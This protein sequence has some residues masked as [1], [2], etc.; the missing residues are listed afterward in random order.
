MRPERFELPT[1]WLVAVA[2]H[3]INEWHGQRPRAPNCTQ[4]YMN[5]RVTRTSPTIGHTQSGLVVAIL[6]AT[7]LRAIRKDRVSPLLWR[8]RRLCRRASCQN[9]GSSDVR[10]IFSDSSSTYWACCRSG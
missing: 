9:F 1:F 7:P 4:V 3:K 2:A 8:L 5:K 6:R 10:K